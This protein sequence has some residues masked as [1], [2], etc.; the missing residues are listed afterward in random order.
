[1]FKTRF[2]EHL[3]VEFPI[4]CGTMMNISDGPFVA[5][6]AQ[7][8]IFSCLASAMFPTE[9]LL[10]AEIKKIRDLT[11]QP[12]GVNIS[13]FPSLLPLPVERTLDILADQGIRILETAG[14]NPG[15]YRE[16]IQERNF[17]HIHKCARLRDAVKAEKVGV[18]MVAVVGTECG[19]HPSMEEVTS[20]ILIPEVADRIRIPLIAGGGFCDG[21]SLVAALALGASGILMGTRFLVSQESRVHP[22][23]KEKLIQAQDSDTLII[24]KS[25][26]SAVRVLKNGWAE[27]V[28]ELERKGAALDELIPYISGKYT[29]AAW[30]SGS[31]EAIFACGQVVGRI[32]ESGAIKE[33]VERIMAEADEMAQKIWQ[34]R[35]T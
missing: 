18:D 32:M 19:G 16:Y 28:L 7:A 25:I 13:L 9:E 8:G 1:M 5:A 30:T 35:N 11:D 23:L 22:D 12:F 33:M 6:G 26:G 29:A 20:L 3:G 27:S 4:Q 24:Q 10:I 31:D 14:R 21:K 15:P 2:T 17:F 34:I